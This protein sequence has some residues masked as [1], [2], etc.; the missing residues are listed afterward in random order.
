MP[1]IQVADKPTLDRVDTNTRGLSGLAGLDD[2]IIACN[3]GIKIDTGSV[4]IKIPFAY[5]KSSSFWK[6]GFDEYNR[7]EVLDKKTHG[8]SMIN[9]SVSSFANGQS[10]GSAYNSLPESFSDLEY[11]YLFTS[12]V[13]TPSMTAYDASKVYY[14][15][16]LTSF[17]DSGTDM[18]GFSGREG[19]TFI[20]SI[21][22]D[23]DNLGDATSQKWYSTVHVSLNNGNV[24][25]KFDGTSE[26]SDR[27]VTVCLVWRL[28]DQD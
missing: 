20:S 4:L 26:A 1:T 14:V 11:L 24:K 21:G 15:Q 8:T 23:Y 2:L 7:V 27:Y 3:R 22:E 16:K 12:Q 9:T 5:D 19:K 10:L 18:K 17:D 28:K 13:Q 6:Y 25:V